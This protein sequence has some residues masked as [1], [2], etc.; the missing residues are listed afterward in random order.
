MHEADGQKVTCQRQVPR[1]AIREIQNHCQQGHGDV[2]PETHH[3][4]FD[5]FRTQK[6]KQWLQWPVQHNAAMSRGMAI[7]R[8]STVKVSKPAMASASR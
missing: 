2:E 3:R 7:R 4:S 6:R 1:V 5:A 8:P